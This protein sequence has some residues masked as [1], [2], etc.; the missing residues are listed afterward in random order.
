MKT[1]DLARMANQIARYFSAY[2]KDEAI[3]GIAKHIHNSWDPRMRNELKAH[4]DNGGEGLSPLFLE[5][6]KLYYKGPAAPG[7]KAKVNPKTQA[8]K[9]AE[10]SFADGG[11]DAG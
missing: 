2:P 6:M 4:I 5:A 8:P 1:S 9:G 10:P 11:G 7:K 3:V